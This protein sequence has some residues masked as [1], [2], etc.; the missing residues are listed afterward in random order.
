MAGR[1]SGP[2]R[3][4]QGG[5][6]AQG[7]CR[8]ALGGADAPLLCL[9]RPGHAIARP[10]TRMTTGAPPLPGARSFF[11]PWGGCGSLFRPCRTLPA[12][13]PRPSPDSHPPFPCWRSGEQA[14]TAPAGRCRGSVPVRHRG[15]QQVRSCPCH[16]G[17]TAAGAPPTTRLQSHHNP[18]AI[19]QPRGT[20]L[21]LPARIAVPAA[22]SV[23]ATM[24]AFRLQLR[25]GDQV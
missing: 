4:M 1:S 22:M 3:A 12:F 18:R 20:A 19:R 8:R 2:H 13:R 16:A 9:M 25:P 11:R 7:A 23:P 24:R 6:N 17:P 15:G 5:P 14:T 21:R 10:S